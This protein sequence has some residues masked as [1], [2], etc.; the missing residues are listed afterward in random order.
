VAFEPV[1]QTFDHL[2]TNIRLNDFGERIEAVMACVGR[3]KGTAE[4]TTGLGPMNH[5]AVPGEPAANSTVPMVALDSYLNRPPTLLKIDVEGFEG[6]V[7]T[8]AAKW[9]ADTGLLAVTIEMGQAP[10]RYGS[11]ENAIHDQMLSLGFKTFDYEPFTRALTPSPGISQSENNTIY[12]RNLNAVEHRL[13]AARR[14]SVQ[15]R[16]V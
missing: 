15:N 6:E 13:Q 10:Q 11:H 14:F 2:R 4:M 3:M 1:E 12:V 5:V 7:L 16:L 9:L 8:G